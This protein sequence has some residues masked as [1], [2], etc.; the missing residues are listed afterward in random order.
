M[1]YQKHVYEFFIFKL[2]NKEF[3]KRLRSCLEFTR[4]FNTGQVDQFLASTIICQSH[5]C[6]RQF[7]RALV[8][9][10]G[11]WKRSIPTGIFLANGKCIRTSRTALTEKPISLEDFHS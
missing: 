6:L 2:M 5:A 9:K 1:S 11:S 8:K 4:Q 10:P 7:S 3:E